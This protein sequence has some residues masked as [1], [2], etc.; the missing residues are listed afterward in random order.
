E[1][2]EAPAGGPLDPE[3]RLRV[4]ERHALELEV[5]WDEA[6]R[7]RVH[8]TLGPQE[9]E[10]DDPGLLD[11]GRLLYAHRSGFRAAE[12]AG[13]GCVGGWEGARP[14]LEA[15]LAEEILVRVG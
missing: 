15:L 13:W 1:P 3:Q 4:A 6:G 10:L 8:L 5:D 9:V 12:A 11:F 2:G 7:A 14:L